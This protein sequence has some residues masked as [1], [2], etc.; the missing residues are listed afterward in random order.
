MMQQQSL[1]RK[2]GLSLTDKSLM[3]RMTKLLHLID[4][5]KR[6]PQDELVWLGTEAK[7]FFTKPIREAYHLLEAEF[8]AD[9]IAVA[10]IHGTSSTPAGT[11]GSAGEPRPRSNCSRALHVIA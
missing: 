4:A 5:G 6:L 7:E 1:Y 2:Y 3:P 8:H 9:S 11:T 10:A